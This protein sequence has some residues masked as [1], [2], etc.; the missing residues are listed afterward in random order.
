MVRRCRYFGGSSPHTRG[1][2]LS[3]PPTSPTVRIIPA[4]AGSTAVASPGISSSWDHP[5]I[6]GEHRPRMSIPFSSLGSSPHTR[7]AR[8]RVFR[9][10]IPAG[11]IPAY[12]GSTWLALEAAFWSLDHPRIRGEHLQCLFH[13]PEPGGSS[14]HTRGARRLRH[15]DRAGARIIP[16]YAGSTVADAGWRGDNGDHPRIRGEHFGGNTKEA[17]DAG[18]SPHTRGAP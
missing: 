4:Y 5:R 1:A 3:R 14:P 11:I 6:R 2:P 18:S 9:R 7:G 13:F 16:A 12:A 8:G 15:G 10:W 17:V